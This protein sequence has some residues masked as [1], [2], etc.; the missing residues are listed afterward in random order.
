MEVLQA[1]P[2][3]R[4]KWINYSAYD[5]KSTWD[6]HAALESRLA[7]MPAAPDAGLLGHYAAAGVSLSSLLDVYRTFWRPF[8]ELLT[9]MEAAGM[10]VDR[11]HLAAAQV[12]ATADQETAKTRFRGW[13]AARVPDAAYMNVGS[14]PQ[15][16]QLLFAGVPNRNERGEREGVPLERLFKVP[17]QRPLGEG[18][19]K[20]KKT[21]DIRLHGVWGPGLRSPLV[22]EIYT[23][24]GMPACST[25]VLKGLAG[26][27]GRA[28]RALAEM[29]AQHDA[30]EGG[31]CGE[32][33]VLGVRWGCVLCCWVREQG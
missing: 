7:A 18:E 19:K 22:P 6:L 5:A 33:W 27:A 2:A 12:Q 20:L 28:R 21:M 24:G 8:G 23:P 15:V 32:G 31:A 26:K 25:P 30:G 13:A 10:A 3:T 4:W 9:E 14:G 11:P 16:S 17:N 1:D 29:E